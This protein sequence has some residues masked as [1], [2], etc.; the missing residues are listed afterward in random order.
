MIM[1][2]MRFIKWLALYEI[3]YVNVIGVVV[4]TMNRPIRKTVKNGTN[5]S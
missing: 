5:A 1:I 2:G 4:N 3:S